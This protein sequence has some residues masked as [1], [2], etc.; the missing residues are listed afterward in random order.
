LVSIF[1]FRVRCGRDR[2]VLLTLD[3]YEELSFSEEITHLVCSRPRLLLARRFATAIHSGLRK[4]H[5]S[6]SRRVISPKQYMAHFF[7]DPWH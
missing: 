1:H 4:V 3:T 5:G 2:A 6:F 7:V